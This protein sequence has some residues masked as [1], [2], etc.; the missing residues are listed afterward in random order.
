MDHLQ[1]LVRGL[2]FHPLLRANRDVGPEFV[3]L[4][5]LR[6]GDKTGPG[7]NQCKIGYPAEAVARGCRQC[8]GL[9]IA[10]VAE[11][12][13]VVAATLARPGMIDEIVEFIEGRDGL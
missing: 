2:W 4:A 6:Q 5:T 11:K 10:V 12:A 7:C 13:T 8:L 1:P 3:A 9:R